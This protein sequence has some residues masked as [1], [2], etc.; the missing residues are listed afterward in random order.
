MSR[1]FEISSRTNLSSND[2]KAMTIPYLYCR[3]KSESSIVSIS[4]F[5]TSTDDNLF[6]WTAF[7]ERTNYTHERNLAC[8]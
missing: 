2:S 5:I 3:K 6:E 4:S 7:N 1:N 8:I